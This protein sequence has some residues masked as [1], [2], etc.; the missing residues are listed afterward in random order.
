MAFIGLWIVALGIL[1]LVLI[2]GM[3]R[4]SD[5][6][7]FGSLAAMGITLI[8]ALFAFGVWLVFA[9]PSDPPLLEGACYRVYGTNSILPISTGKSMILIPYHGQQLVQVTCP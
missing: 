1:S 6:L 4:D 9:P 3:A 5:R 8:I 7:I 2:V